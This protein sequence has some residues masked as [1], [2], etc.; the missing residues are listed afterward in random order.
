VDCRR[1]VGGGSGGPHSV[2][3]SGRAAAALIEC[4]MEM[5]NV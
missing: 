1:R 3:G 2:A 5:R 4:H